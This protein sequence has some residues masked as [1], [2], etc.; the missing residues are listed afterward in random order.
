MDNNPEELEFYTDEQWEEAIANRINLLIDELVDVMNHQIH[1]NA[2]GPREVAKRLYKI[3]LYYEYLDD[4]DKQLLDLV[5][6]A[7]KEGHKFK[8]EKKS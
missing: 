6:E 2:W 3:E 5:I 7:N 8:L 4:D 1:L